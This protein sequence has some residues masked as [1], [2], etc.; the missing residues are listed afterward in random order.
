MLVHFYEPTLRI[1]GSL[2]VT[3]NIFN[4][5]ISTVNLILKEWMNSDDVDVRFMGQK[6]KEKYDKYWGDVNKMNKLIY[7]AVVVDPRYKLEF[8]EFALGEEYGKEVG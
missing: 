8:I 4:H 2:Y 3:S 7:V 6:M 5:E 1:S